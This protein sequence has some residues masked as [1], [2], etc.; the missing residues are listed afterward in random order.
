MTSNKQLIGSKNRWIKVNTPMNLAPQKS[1][2]RILNGTPKSCILIGSSIINTINHP[3]WGSLIFG[4]IHISP[5]SMGFDLSFGS[6]G[7]WESCCRSYCAVV[8]S[9]ERAEPLDFCSHPRTGY[10]VCISQVLDV[11][12][13]FT[14]I[15]P[16][17]YPNVGTVNRPY[18]VRMGM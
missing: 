3:F 13:I 11:W 10:D 16:Q 6:P 4:N 17:K 9:L 5:K 7:R 18:I 15:Y 1:V 2:T 14:Y 8:G 12:E